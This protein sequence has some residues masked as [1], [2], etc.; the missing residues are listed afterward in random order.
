MLGSHPEKA[1][2]TRDEERRELLWE[3]TGFQRALHVRRNPMP[4]LGSVL[5][6]IIQKGRRKLKEW[7]KSVLLS[8]LEEFR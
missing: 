5:I 1:S 2:E 8:R 6:S 4:T 3:D 7:A